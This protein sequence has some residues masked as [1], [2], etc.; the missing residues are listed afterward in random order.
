MGSPFGPG[1]LA[2][3]NCSYNGTPDGGRIVDV[4]GMSELLCVVHALTI[5]IIRVPAT[6][7]EHIVPIGIAPSVPR[8]N[9]TYFLATS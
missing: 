1:E 6:T 5:A 4:R 8:T 3:S 2:D 7:R 9:E